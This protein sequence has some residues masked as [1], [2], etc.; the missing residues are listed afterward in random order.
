MKAFCYIL[1]SNKLNIFYTGASQ[2]D[3]EVRI[4]KHNTGYYGKDKFTAKTNDWSLFHS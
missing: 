3:I 1:F 2:D 4:Q